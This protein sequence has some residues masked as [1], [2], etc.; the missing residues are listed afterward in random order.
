MDVKPSPKHIGIIGGMGPRATLCFLNHVIEYSQKRYGAKRDEEFPR[1]S[2]ES[3]PLPGFTARELPEQVLVKNILKSAYE[4]LE[5]VGASVVA[6]PCNTMHGML[7]DVVGTIPMVNLVEETARVAKLRGLTRPYIL[8]TR[9]T[10]E[11][12]V[13]DHAYA[14]YE[15]QTLIPSEAMQKEVDSLITNIEEGNVSQEYMKGLLPLLEEAKKVGADHF[16]LGCTE[17]SLIPGEFFG[18]MKILD[19]SLIGAQK[20]VDFAY[21]TTAVELVLDSSATSIPASAA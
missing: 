1:I 14:S 10:Q 4:R 17:L 19:S 21:A 18:D 11:S 13:Y 8:S 12:K 5:S 15:I 16:V 7:E 2:M 9:M 6:I 3:I 20:L